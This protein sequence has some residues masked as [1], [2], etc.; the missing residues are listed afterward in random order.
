MNKIAEK[1]LRPD[2]RT[3][4]IMGVIFRTCTFASAGFGSFL[5]F[6]MGLFSESGV[7][8]CIALA[9]IAMLNLVLFYPERSLLKDRGLVITVSIICLVLGLFSMKTLLSGCSMYNN[10]WLFMTIGFF[11]KPTLILIESMKQQASNKPIQPIAG[12]TGSG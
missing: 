11:A 5:I 3:L 2:Q 6:L 12:N 8:W 7:I 1:I 4:T 9:L 10:Q